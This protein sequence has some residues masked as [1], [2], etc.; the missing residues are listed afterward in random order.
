M[1]IELL[2]GEPSTR[3]VGAA[4]V[5]PDRAG[6]VVDFGPADGPP[7]THLRLSIA[8]AKRLSAALKAVV[9]GRDEEILLVED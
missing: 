8:E 3:L 1:R 5:R 7:L 6:I 9:D 2:D 4:V